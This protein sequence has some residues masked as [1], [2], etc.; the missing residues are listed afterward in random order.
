MDFL[1]AKSV[2]GLY[3]MAL[4]SGKGGLSGDVSVVGRKVKLIMFVAPQI[5]ASQ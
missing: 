5:R 2:Q 1:T 4:R 3:K